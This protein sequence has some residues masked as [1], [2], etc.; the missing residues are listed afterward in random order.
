MAWSLSGFTF[1]FQVAFDAGPR[2]GSPTWVDVTTD[3]RAAE[4]F[5]SRRGRTDGYSRV[6]SGT[7]DVS[8]RNGTE[9][10]A[11][12]GRWT[13]GV[14]AGPWHPLKLRRQARLQVQ[15]SSVWYDLWAGHV[16]D[17]APKWV[18]AASPVCDLSLSDLL[19][20]LAITRLPSLVVGEMLSDAPALMYPLDDDAASSTAGDRSGIDGIPTLGIVQVGSNG[21]LAFGAGLAPGPDG[22]TVAAFTTGT[23]SYDASN[24]KMLKTASSVSTIINSGFGGDVLAAMLRPSG[25]RAMTALSAEGA[26]SIT[27]RVGTSASGKAVGTIVSPLDA[28]NVTLTGSTTLPLTSATAVAL[29]QSVSA[30]TVTCDLLVNGA[31]EATTTYARAFVLSACPDLYVGGQAGGALWDGQISHVAW[32]NTAVSTARLLEQSN[33]RTGF[34]AERTDQRFARLCRIAGLPSTLYTAGTGLSTMCAQP[35]AGQSLPEA[36]AKVQDAEAGVVGIDAAGKL[37]LYPRDARY[38]AAV[39]LTLDAR[40]EILNDLSGFVVND[41]RSEEHTSE[42]QSQR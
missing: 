36:L 9:G 11:V 4:G 16:S 24:G 35:V 3:V 12:A 13:P 23:G 26:L 22:G 20:N 31:V 17:L 32:Y 14:A 7:A 39:A 30:G 29:R 19:A 8:M 15:W 21:T 5:T 27:I 33:A 37:R 40:T 1:R 2:N 34:L 6:A 25:S 42:L 10:G 38:N 41:E 28:V 18:G